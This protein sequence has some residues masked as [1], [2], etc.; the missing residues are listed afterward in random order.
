[1]CG[2]YIKP[3]CLG[4]LARGCSSG[5][6]GRFQAPLCLST[7]RFE[8]CTPHVS[9][10]VG[11]DNNCLS[12]LLCFL[13]VAGQA[14]DELLLVRMPPPPPT[15]A[16]ASTLPVYVFDLD[17]VLMP[18]DALFAQPRVR[19]ILH[20]LNK[21]D[22]PQ[23]HAAYQQFVARD[24]LLI[25][26][27]S[28]LRGDRYLLTNGSQAHALAST[29]ALGVY[30]YLRDVVHAQSGYGLKP[31]AGPY[32]RIE[33][34]VRARHAVH[35]PLDQPAALPPI[36]FFDD[37]LENLVYPKQRGWTTVWIPPSAAQAEMG[38]NGFLQPPAYVDY[39]FPNVYV[40]LEYF[41][42]VQEQY[43]Q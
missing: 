3:R 28:A 15:T 31:Q 27:L 7:R 26:R 20:S 21:E 13:S 4:Q 42:M 2:L 30:P 36:V 18:T 19:A 32:H 23:F 22:Y 33:T 37:R 12:F 8:S 14:A 9:P 24:P 25:Y 16:S 11:T 38:D 1:M 41:L 43:R 17:D 5:L 35:V 29:H 6:R 34:I 39:T 40:A 10:V